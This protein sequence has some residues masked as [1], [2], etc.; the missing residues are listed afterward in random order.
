MASPMLAFMAGLGQGYVRSS[1]KARDDARRDKI[2]QIIFDRADRESAEYQRTKDFRDQL[3]NAAKPVEARPINASMPE[4]DE[5]G[6]MVPAAP[7]RDLNM[8]GEKF[9]PS[10]GDARTAATAA[11]TPEAQNE[12][13]LAVMRGHDPVKAQ[14]L[15]TSQMQGKVAGLNLEKGQM[16]LANAKFD[17]A[18]AG[19]GTHED[20]AK[21][22]GQMGV[23]LEARQGADGKVE[24][25]QV[26]ADGKAVKTPYSFAD[27]PE[28]VQEA[29]LA[30]SRATP[31]T[32]K[33]EFAFKRDESRRNQENQDRR[34]ALEEKSQ[35]ALERYRNATLG[36][37]QRR[38]GLAEA[39]AKAE[40][41]IPAA[42]KLQYAG[43]DKEMQT[44]SSAVAKAQAEGMFDPN[45]PNAQALLAKQAVLAG[46][47]MRLMAP[48]TGN[49]GAVA[50][51]LGIMGDEK[52]AP[53]KEPAR[54]EAKKPPPKPDVSPSFMQKIGNAVSGAADVVGKNPVVRWMG[55]VGRDYTSPEGVAA[56]KQRVD[57]AKA[58]GTPLSDVETMR[59]RQAR[60]I[61]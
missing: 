51:P 8:A 3:A 10:M 17:Q 9:Y 34:F 46:K 15:Q 29:K 24:Y 31:L 27:T 54:T 23:K 13:I 55:E 49:A 2:D 16:D 18:I 12:R 33:I 60:L 42:V 11:N 25:W 58:G 4:M 39:A 28:G 48:Y 22:A 61:P 40:A 19:L 26:G 32:S 47:M 21:A 1:D 45:S 35:G 56:I 44:I 43:L 30:L 59:A 37:E 52:P 7:P 20:I 14:H 38:L 5:Q 53:K 57:E 41:R 6:N 50:D 36:M